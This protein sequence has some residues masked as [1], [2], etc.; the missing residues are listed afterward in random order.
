M[1]TKTTE[2]RAHKIAKE[3]VEFKIH[4]LSYLLV[5]SF[6]LILNLILTPEYLWFVWPLMGWGIGLIIHGVNAHFS[7]G[8][9]LKER[10]IEKEM[11][12]VG[13]IISFMLIM[14][15]MN[16]QD[17]QTSTSFSGYGGPFVS[18]TQI[19]DDLHL[20]IGGKGG[21]VINHKYA[22][23]GLGYGM[24]YP[25]DFNGNDL[26]GNTNAS[27]QKSFG[28]GG[29]FFE[30]IHNSGDLVHFTIPVNLMAGEMGIYEDDGETEIES[31]GL[32]IIEPGISLDLNVAE[33][34][35]PSLYVSYRFALGSSLENIEDEDISGLNVGLIFKFG[36]Q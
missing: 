25:T 30:Y 1:N 32:F 8:S 27:L 23:G 26:S 22:F 4:L 10:M 19:N 33:T 14:A 34:F 36:K 35:T 2:Q 18:A 20:L 11:K 16:A 9:S 24:V 7:Q 21:V 17:Q 31:S 13:L 3:R 28:A 29:V 12:K 5:N 6:L 15:N